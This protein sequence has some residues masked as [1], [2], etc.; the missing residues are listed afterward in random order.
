VTALDVPVAHDE[1]SAIGAVREVVYVGSGTR[2]I[3]GLEAGGELVALQQ[4]VDASPQASA[5]LRGQNV[6]LVWNKQHEY[7]VGSS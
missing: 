2:F 6:R 1:G 7:R 4:N 5:E 3:V